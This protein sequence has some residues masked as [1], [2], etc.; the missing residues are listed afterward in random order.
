M[1]PSI[2]PH[3]RAQIQARE[4][5]VWASSL[6]FKT[7]SQIAAEE[8]V[9]RPM[10]SKILDRLV[11][12]ARAKLAQEVG[13]TLVRQL[14]Q[15]RKTIAEMWASWERSKQPKARVKRKKSVTGESAGEEQTSET[16]AGNVAFLRLALE[17]MEHEMKLLGQAVPPP[18]APTDPISGSAPEL[19]DLSVEELHERVVQLAARLNAVRGPLS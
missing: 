6:V 3:N 11:V 17:A 16:Q 12:R 8:H 13:E 18:L 14:A 1:P 15:V 9:S 4:E 5:R 2:D 19:R 10:I 7:H